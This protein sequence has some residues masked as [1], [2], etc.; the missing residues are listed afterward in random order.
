[1]AESIPGF[2]GRPAGTFIL[3]EK[4]DGLTVLEPLSP[5]EAASPAAEAYLTAYRML[6]CGDPGAAAAFESIASEPDGDPL[7]RFH[8]ARLRSGESGT[9]VVMAEK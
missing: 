8:L 5:G 1:M 6:D 4:S 2:A 3:Q 9:T 7:A